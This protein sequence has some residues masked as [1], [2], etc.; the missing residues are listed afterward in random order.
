MQPTDNEPGLSS[1]SIELIVAYLDENYNIEENIEEGII[2]FFKFVSDHLFPIIEFKDS[3]KTISTNYDS[4]IYI[5]DNTNKEN[6]IVK[7]LD[8]NKWDEI[9]EEAEDAFDTL[10]IAQ[11]KN[12]KGD[13]IQEWKRVFG[14]T[15]NLE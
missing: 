6:N 14:P 12:N 8:K 2:R 3:I 4:P 15:F 11:S 9:V 5:S 13:T 1:F 10:N 7:R